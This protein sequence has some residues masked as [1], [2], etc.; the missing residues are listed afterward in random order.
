M[1]YIIFLIKLPSHVLLHAFLFSLIVLSLSCASLDYEKRDAIAYQ[2]NIRNIYENLSE[3]KSASDMRVW[4]NS[5]Y[6]NESQKKE[7]Q[8]I[9]HKDIGVNKDDKPTLKTKKIGLYLL[10]KMQKFRGPAQQIDYIDYLKLWKDIL[11][12]KLNVACYE[13]SSM[14]AFF[15]NNSG[16]VTRVVNIRSRSPDG[17]LEMHTV[18]ESYDTELKK[19]YM[20]DLTYKHVYVKNKD[21]QLLTTLDYLNTLV[22][23]KNILEMS[24]F[25]GKRYVRVS[26]PR[27]PF[28]KEMVQVLTRYYTKYTTLYYPN[29]KE[30]SWKNSFK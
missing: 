2:N 14:Y 11:K 18:A 20:V 22:E 17:L 24:I 10:T 25:N 23:N 7:V 3:S 6:F 4:V 26:D 1:N 12:G 8:K 15:A 29:Q 5:D 19:W 21:G 30:I 13:F 9:L 28:F 27:K 16:V